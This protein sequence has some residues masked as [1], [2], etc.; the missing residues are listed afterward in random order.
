L[1]FLLAFKPVA[2]RPFSVV[3]E[4]AFKY[5]FGSKLFLWKKERTKETKNI[6]TV[7]RKE[8]QSKPVVAIP[9]VIEGKLDDMALSLDTQKGAPSKQ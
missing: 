9:K 1:A 2:G 6:K 8:D 5:T 3:L 7:L 4:S